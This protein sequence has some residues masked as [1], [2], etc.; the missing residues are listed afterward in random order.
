MSVT[1]ACSSHHHASRV[2]RGPGGRRQPAANDATLPLHVNNRYGRAKHR[3]EEDEAQVLRPRILNVEAR[4]LVSP[5]SSRRAILDESGYPFG[6]WI[7]SYR[8]WL[9]KLGQLHLQ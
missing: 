5:L 4:E 9:R 2:A 7:K 3:L 1:R 8:D 6:R